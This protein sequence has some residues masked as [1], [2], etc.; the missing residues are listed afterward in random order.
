MLSLA[1]ANPAGVAETIANLLLPSAGNYYAKITG[2]EDTIQMYELALT[3]T[4]ML[5][6]DYN[7]NGVVDAA[8]YIVWRNSLGQS[9]AAGTGADGN[10]DGLITQ[11]DYDLWRSHFGQTASGSGSA[12]ASGAAAVPEPG[13][14]TFGLIAAAA[15]TFVRRR[16]CALFSGEISPSG[17]NRFRRLGAG[18]V[19][20]AIMICE[21]EPPTMAS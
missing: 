1:N 14:A 3:A 20:L 15:M 11:A 9:I 10:G 18:W 12:L 6:G 16:A 7:H 8:D 19:L 4:A 2:A 17:Y 5:P 21:R 13:I